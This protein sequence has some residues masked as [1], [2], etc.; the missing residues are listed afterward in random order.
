VTLLRL[1]M[2]PVQEF[3]KVEVSGGLLL[4]GATAVALFLANSPLSDGYADFWLT[5]VGFR[6]GEVTLV[7]PL[8]QWVNEGLM[9][10]FFFV[11]GLEIKRELTNGELADKRK[12]ALPCIGALGGMIVPA[13]IYAGFNVGGAVEGWATP[14][15]TDIAFALGVLALAGSRVPPAAKLFLLSLAI[16]DDI[17]SILVVAVFYSGDLSA[18]WI[19]AAVAGLFL[20]YY[21]RRSEVCSVPV[22]VVVGGIVWLCMLEGGV[23]ATLTGVA[24]GL[25][26][27]ARNHFGEH[28]PTVTE[29][30]EK[31][32]HPY[33]S[34]LILPVFAVANAGIVVSASVVSEAITSPVMLG[35]LA[36]RTLGK[37]IGIVL[38]V[39]LAVRLG[40]GVLPKSLNWH[41]MVG[42]GTA[43]GAGFTVALFITELAFGASIAGEQAKLGILFGT[44][45]SGVAGVALMRR[46]PPYSE[47]SEVVDVRDKQTT[48]VVQPEL[49]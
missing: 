35:V 32:L 48:R 37:P 31:S 38:A 44:V 23:P 9:T 49:V 33:S 36:A 1:A 20:V 18:A 41:H 25:L 13:L 45:I 7:E 8:R 12:A 19:A 30:L 40:V 17:G 15:A 3:L 11:A 6:I 24:M 5:E 43:A 28:A 16:A 46:C 39:W 14:M 47:P 27:P 10:I 2:R 29:K 21:L 22:Y 34:F 42:I 26:A 4:V